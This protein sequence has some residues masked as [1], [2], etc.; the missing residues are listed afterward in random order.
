[1]VLATFSVSTKISGVR[2]NPHNSSVG[3][4]GTPRARS[5]KVTIL[6]CATWSLFLDSNPTMSYNLT[7]VTD[8]DVVVISCNVN[9]TAAGRMTA[10]MIWSNCSS[11]STSTSNSYST[12]TTSSVSFIA[13]PPTLPPCTCTTRFNAPLNSSPDAATNAPSYNYSI[14]SPSTILGSCRHELRLYNRQQQSSANWI[15]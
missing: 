11:T 4:V 13:R 2:L 12:F 14:S 3:Y 5:C 7:C 10:S 6:E 9:Y 8:G 1:M 15:M